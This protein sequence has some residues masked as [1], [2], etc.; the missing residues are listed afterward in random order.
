MLSLAFSWY[1]KFGANRLDEIH[2]ADTISPLISL[3]VFVLAI[4]FDAN[5]I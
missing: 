2:L 1:T 3:G 5:I 4:N